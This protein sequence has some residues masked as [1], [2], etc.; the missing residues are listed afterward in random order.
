MRSSAER[1]VTRQ[2]AERLLDDHPAAPA[3]LRLLRDVLGREASEPE[4]RRARREL[5]G[6]PALRT[7]VAAQQPDGGWGR[8]HSRDARGRRSSP[9]TEFA[10]RRGCA[11]GLPARYGMLVRARA[12]CEDLLRGRLCFPDPP[13]RNDRWETGWQLFV[14]ATLARIAPASPALRPTLRLWRAVLAESF[15][16]GRYDPRAEIAA[17]RRLT[18]ATVEGSYLR[19]SSRY[20]VELLAVRARE[21]PEEQL[22]AYLG[23]LTA[24]APGLGYL[25]V[26]L[27]PTARLRGP[28][29]PDAWLLSWELLACLP[30][31]ER[32]AAPLARWLWARRTPEGLWDL[33]PRSPRS[34]TF[35]LAP[36]WRTAGTRRSDWSARVL[37]LLAQ[38]MR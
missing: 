17:Q 20:A 13:E 11:L 36:S 7:L 37:S 19:L 23:W 2:L 1:R 24:R 32:H 9:T 16:S 14:A 33:G 31:W 6:H 22:D 30:G 3:R 5:S 10:V 27:R 26:P 29:S 28:T 4:V 12:H 34:E 38:R 35:P 8:F 21:I 15:D 18:G 25:E